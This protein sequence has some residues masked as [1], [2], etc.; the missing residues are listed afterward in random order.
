MWDIAVHIVSVTEHSVAA[1]GERS[2]II[3]LITANQTAESRRITRIPEH[4]VPR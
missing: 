3:E 1:C 4:V 2:C